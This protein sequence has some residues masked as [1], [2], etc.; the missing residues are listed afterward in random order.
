MAQPTRRDDLNHKNKICL[1]AE[2]IWLE[3]K[4]LM[5]VCVL[6]D[7]HH[8]DWCARKHSLKSAEVPQKLHNFV[9]CYILATCLNAA[10]S[11]IFLHLRRG[12]AR[13]DTLRGAPS[14]RQ[15]F[16]RLW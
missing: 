3:S 8:A 5:Q 11:Y 12:S 10:K 13:G 6:G 16:R 4:L 9:K 2:V 15:P 1:P 7:V 14:P